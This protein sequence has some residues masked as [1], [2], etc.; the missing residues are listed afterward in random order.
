MLVGSSW[1]G[2]LRYGDR[3]GTI[4]NLEVSELRELLAT[5]IE[6]AEIWLG[7]LM[8]DL[9]STNVPT[10]GESFAANFALVWT[11][12]CMASLMGL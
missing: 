3:A 10:L 9:V 5:L 12:A 1:E 7:L 11:F 2:D 4:S 6:A 8:N